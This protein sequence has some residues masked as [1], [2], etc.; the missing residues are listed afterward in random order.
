MI[1]VNLPDGTV[2]R[3][4]EGTSEEV[5]RQAIKKLPVK[6]TTEEAFTQPTVE[7]QPKESNPFGSDNRQADLA[8]ND[9]FFNTIQRSESVV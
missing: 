4:P 1:K 3:F 8:T 7:T 6:D 2:L 9:E 5:M